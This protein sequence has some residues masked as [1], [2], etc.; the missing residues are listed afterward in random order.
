MK[1]SRGDVVLVDFPFVSGLGAKVRPALVVQNDRD[2]QRLTNTIIAMITSRT[3]RATET[4]Q[5]F[6]DINT[7]EGKQTGLIMDSVVNCINLFT[8]EQSQIVRKLGRFSVLY[9]TQVGE[10]LKAALSLS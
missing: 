9:V 4:T 5:L 3:H 8:L 10:C 1:I 6:I 7:P 2:N